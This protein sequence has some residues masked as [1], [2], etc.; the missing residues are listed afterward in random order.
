MYIYLKQNVTKEQSNRDNESDKNED[1]FRRRR[2]NS[3]LKLKDEIW[4]RSYQHQPSR[5]ACFDVC[6][7]ARA[8]YMRN[9]GHGLDRE[10]GFLVFRKEGNFQH[11]WKFQVRKY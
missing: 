2:G 4:H 5:P 3:I 8:G 6:S 11:L 10:C 9:N 1:F 7:Y